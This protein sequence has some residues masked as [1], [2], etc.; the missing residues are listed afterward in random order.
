MLDPAFR[1]VIQKPL[2]AAG[3]W[4]AGMGLSANHVTIAASSLVSL[5]PSLS[6]TALSQSGCSYFFSA[7]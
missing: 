6:L 3:R 2:N 4:L 7:G 1:P 5:R